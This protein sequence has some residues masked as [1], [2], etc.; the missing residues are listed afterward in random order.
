MTGADDRDARYARLMC[1]AQGGDPAAYAKLLRDLAPLLRRMVR[2]RQPFALQPPDVEDLVQDILLSLHAARGTYDPDRPFV[3]WLAAIVRNRMADAAR[4]AVR[5]RNE[6]LT[7]EPLPETFS[8]DAANTIEDAYGDP[9][10]LRYAIAT[11]PGGQKQAV[12]LL[13]LREL[14]LREASAVSG[15]SVGALK[16]AVHRGIRTLRMKLTREA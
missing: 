15:M 1:A 6:Q 8:T 10:A 16:V 12:E 11:L 4:R 14:S 13:K 9:E 7:V 5:R 3:P 2:R